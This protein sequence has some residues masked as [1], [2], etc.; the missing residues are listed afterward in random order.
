MYERADDMHPCAT[1]SI[2][3]PL[4]IRVSVDSRAQ[5]RRSTWAGMHA[6]KGLDFSRSRR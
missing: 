1:N 4:S 5:T 6:H 3:L 2:G